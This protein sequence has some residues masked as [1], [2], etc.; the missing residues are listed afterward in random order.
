MATESNT[1]LEHT[2]DEEDDRREAIL[3][4]AGFDRNRH[5]DIYDRLADK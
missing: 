1:D 5:R 3:R 2:D 4:F